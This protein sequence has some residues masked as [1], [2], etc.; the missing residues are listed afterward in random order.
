MANGS[1][2]G[3]TGI[4]DDPYLIEDVFDLIAINTT[5][6]SKHYKLTKDIDLNIYPYNTGEGWIPLNYFS[7]VFDGNFHT[8]RNLYMERTSNT[9]GLFSNING[10]FK[11][12]YLEDFRLNFDEVTNNRYYYIGAL[13]GQLSSSAR[14]ENVVVSRVKIF[15]NYYLGGLAG[16]SSASEIINCLVDD[17]EIDNSTGTT[18]STGGFIGR[19][20]ANANMVRYCLVNNFRI[21]TGAPGN[22]SNYVGGFAGYANTSLYNCYWDTTHLNWYGSTG[23]TIGYNYTQMRNPSNFV[24]LG[25]TSR[26]DDV[27]N[28]RNFKAWIID[29]KGLDRPR[30]FMEKGLN[31][32]TITYQSDYTDLVNFGSVIEGEISSY[33]K[34][35]VKTCY[36]V[37]INEIDITWERKEGI[38]ILT[39]LELSTT[40]GFIEPL[41]ELHYTDLNLLRGDELTFYMRVRTSVGMEGEGHFN[42]Y[43]DVRS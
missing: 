11:N 13:A 4:T 28:H 3:G 35:N 14:I 31:K 24:G 6:T 27:L 29:V 18:Y 41:S 17:V 22:Q 34:V 15:G 1:F 38:S 43:V 40:Q 23:G 10:T 12:C 21:T 37:S 7:G 5:G 26:I 30:L 2:G 36:D 19:I 8:I 39:E 42:L 25:A 20:D 16:Y 32:T 9:L 33:R